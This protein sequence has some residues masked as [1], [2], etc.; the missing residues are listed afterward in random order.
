MTFERPVLLLLLVVAPVVHWL[1]GAWLADEEK[2]LKRFV[3]PV[4]WEKVGIEPPPGRL[5]TR[6]LWTLGLL[7]AFFALAGPTWGRDGAFIPVGGR[8][9]AIALDVSRSM[10]CE[11]EAPSR[12]ARAAAEIR[13]LVRAMPGTRFSLVLYSGQ[14]RLAVPITVDSD[15]F[16]SRL[17][18]GIDDPTHLPP[19]TSM[20]NLVE[21]MAQALPGA[22]LE[23]RVGI[24]FSD[25]GFHDMSVHRSIEQ[26]R[27]RGMALVT[28]G[29]GGDTPVTI[30]DHRGGVLVFQGDTVRTVLEEDALIQLAEGTGGFYSRISEVGDLTVPLNSLL[31]MSSMEAR[32]QAANVGP[33]RR[34]QIFLG[35]SL[36]F[37]CAA[38]I[39]ERRGL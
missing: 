20:G 32:L 23:S 9:V 35:A 34:Y 11:D 37:I 22:D 16:F 3:R 21:V 31:D 26:A 1:R 13:R 28:I 15:Y 5:L 36:L 4:L 25:G 24:I 27:N 6:W 30:P 19:G 10:A 18:M 7:M 38:L 33:G 14:S 8:N 12:L 29:V 39:L 2:R 17:P